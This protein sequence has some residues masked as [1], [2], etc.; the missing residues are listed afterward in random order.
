MFLDKIDVRSI[1]SHH[2]DTLYDYGTQRRSASDFVVF[3]GLPILAAVLA[4]W[5]G[6]RIR[7]D[8]VNGLL[9]AFAIFVAIL[10]SVLLM[11]LTFL[12]TTQG[13]PADR[14]VK[15]RKR[16]LREITANLSYTILLSVALVALAII[17]LTLLRKTE[18]PIGPVETFFLVAGSTN[19]VL[20]LLMVLKRMYALVLN[21][22]DRHKLIGRP[23]KVA[24]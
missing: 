15:E 17:T 7:I 24:S 13:D 22:F 12:Q 14:L 23:N 2:F 1:V 6:V 11:V 16:L 8:A 21:E 3:F 19:F 10:P 4:L 18:D 20:T 5:R 9:T